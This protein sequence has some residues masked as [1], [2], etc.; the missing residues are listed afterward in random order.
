MPNLLDVKVRYS[1][2]VSMFCHICENF[3]TVEVLMSCTLQCTAYKSP[4]VII[5][6]MF[7]VFVVE[8][9]FLLK[10]W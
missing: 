1:I 8:V 6:L 2:I 9:D 4:S 10:S 5:C 7:V 3:T